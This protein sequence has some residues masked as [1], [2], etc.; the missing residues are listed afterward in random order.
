MASSEADSWRWPRQVPLQLGVGGGDLG[1]LGVQ[2]GGDLGGF[3][4][5]GVTASKSLG[6]ARTSQFSPSS[7]K[8]FGS[9]VE[10]D[11]GQLLASLSGLTGLAM[12]MTP[13]LVNIQATARLLRPCV[14]AAVLREGVANLGDG[15]VL[16]VGEDLDDDGDAARGRSPRR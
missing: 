3:E 12:A 7:E 1:D 14:V 5:F 9:C 4:G 13:F 8:V 6:S 10:D 11:L 15:A 16:V 2:F